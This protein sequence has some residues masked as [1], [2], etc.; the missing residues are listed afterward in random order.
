MALVSLQNGC[1]F[2][3]VFAY[4]R[5]YCRTSVHYPL[6]SHP[7]VTYVYYSLSFICLNSLTL[8]GYELV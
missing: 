1:S 3:I 5:S 7:R 4:A 8:G 2:W 6:A